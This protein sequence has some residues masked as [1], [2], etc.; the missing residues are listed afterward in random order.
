MGLNDADKISFSAFSAQ[1]A[2]QLILVFG[3][4]RELAPKHTDKGLRTEQLSDWNPE[5]I[6][7]YIHSPPLLHRCESVSIRGCNSGF[8]V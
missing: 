5:E 8:R 2:V 3:F 1:S 4:N 6:S 7:T